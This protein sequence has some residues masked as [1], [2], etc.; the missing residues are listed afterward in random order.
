VL[1]LNPDEELTAES[2]STVV[3][4]VT[5]SDVLA[6]TVVVQEL[7]T[8][9]RPDVFTETVQLRLFQRHP[10]LQF[11]GRLH[12]D[13]VTP[14]D[15]VAARE[16]KA[17]VATGITLRH[18]SYLSVPNE[19]K[20]RWAARLMELELQD[21]PG[22]LPMLIHYGETLL[23]L[24]DPKGHAVLAEAVEKLLPIRNADRPPSP[25]VQ[26]LLDYLL[27]VSAEQSRS[28]L[29]REEA[30]ALAERWFPASP[31]LFWRRAQQLF[32]AG[33]FRQAAVLLENLLEFGRTR[34]YDSS[35][36]FA[37]TIIGDAALA[38]LGACCT[39]LGQLDRAA[40]CFRQLLGSPTHHQEAA[41]NLAVV[42]NLRRQVPPAGS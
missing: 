28:R 19:P 20:L 4:C 21:R 8:A 29:S 36:G 1:W 2:H 5:R 22:Q 13:F 35:H 26:L 9:N 31:P 15:V 10:A 32:E 37:P 17:I 6:Y 41:Q 3:H 30:W 23:R 14:I 42:E 40:Q 25:S 27:G 39:R 12:A 11:I 7:T 16:G 18:H 34:I 38:N 33:D 24:N